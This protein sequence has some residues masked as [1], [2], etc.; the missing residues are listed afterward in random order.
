[1]VRV[2][3][4]SE[5][6]QVE[7]CAARELVSVVDAAD[8]GRRGTFLASA[9]SRLSSNSWEVNERESRNALFGVVRS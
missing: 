5:G 9:W 2:F 3:V 6:R 4:F 7:A 1:V 8:G